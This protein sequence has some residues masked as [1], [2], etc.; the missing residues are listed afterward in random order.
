ML[1]SG[2]F[3]WAETPQVRNGKKVLNRGNRILGIDWG[4]TSYSETVTLG[5]AKK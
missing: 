5:F 2:I 4:K 1:D 3:S